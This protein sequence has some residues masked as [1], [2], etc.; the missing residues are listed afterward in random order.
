[1]LQEIRVKD[2]G[3]NA[4]RYPKPVGEPIPYN[5]TINAQATWPVIGYNLLTPNVNSEAGQQEKKFLE[6]HGINETKLEIFQAHKIFGIRRKIWMQPLKA[7]Y[8]FDGDDL[9]IKFS[10]GAGEYASVL[11][12]KLLQQLS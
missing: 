4:I 3:K 8:H 7:K 5:D 10:L 6:S 11:I 9:V 1:M 2:T 12:D